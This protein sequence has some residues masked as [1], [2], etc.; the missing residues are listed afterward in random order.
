MCLSSAGVSSGKLSSGINMCVVDRI[1]GGL[2]SSRG[3]DVRMYKI[4]SIRRRINGENTVVYNR[5]MGPSV[6]V[7]VSMSFTASIPSYPGAG[8]KSVTLKG[9]IIVRH[10]V[11]GADS[12]ASLI[13]GVTG[14][15]GVGRRIS[16]E[17]LTIKNAGTII[18]RRA[19][20]NVVAVDLKVPYEC[21]RAPIR[22][23]SLSSV[24]STVRLLCLVVA[25]VGSRVL[26]G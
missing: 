23:Y 7:Y 19:G 2:S 18:L 22:L 3:S 15:G 1:L 14:R 25:G 24:R 4:T 21:V 26:V 9:N 5:G 20:S 16:T 8:C 10:D 13:R 17:A 12:V 6:T 11:S